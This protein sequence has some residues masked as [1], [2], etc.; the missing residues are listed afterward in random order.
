MYSVKG[1]LY[2]WSHSE[3]RWKERG[4][5]KLHINT[6]KDNE[7]ESRLIMRMEAAFRLILNAKVFPQ[8]RCEKA[9]EKTVTIT[10]VGGVEEPELADKLNTFM[11]KLSRK[12]EADELVE[13]LQKYIKLSEEV[14][15]KETTSTGKADETKPQESSKEATTNEKTSKE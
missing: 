6:L 1:K 9:S 3:K 2:L 5:G 13:Q 4:E 7:K 14:K 12:D 10:A 11:I 15:P 8:M